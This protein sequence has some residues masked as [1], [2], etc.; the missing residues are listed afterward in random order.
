M[1]GCCQPSELLFSWLSPYSYT[2]KVVVSEF[3]K[4]IYRML[5]EHPHAQSACQLNK[6]SDDSMRVLSFWKYAP[7]GLS[8][9][10]NAMFLKPA[11][12]IGRTKDIKQ[13]FHQSVTTRI[14]LL[15]VR[16]PVESIRAVTSPATRYLHLRKH[17]PGAFKDCHLHPRASF[18]QV[19]GKK[20]PCSA[21]TNNRRFH[22]CRIVIT[23]DKVNNFFRKIQTILK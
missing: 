21:A 17:L 19:Y 9:K 3:I 23:A 5:R 4:R 15:Q 13:T 11:I 18:F 7:V 8:D 14:D 16:H 1:T 10:R 6:T 2:Y 22:L 20:E 12:G